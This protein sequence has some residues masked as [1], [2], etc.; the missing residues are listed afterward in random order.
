MKQFIKYV[1]ATIVGIAAIVVV[2]TIFSIIMLVGVSMQDSAPVSVADNSVL[3]IKLNGSIDE[4]TKENPLASIINSDVVESNGLDNMLVAIKHAKDNDNIKGIYIETKAFGGANPATLQE[5]RDALVDFKTSGKFI[6]SYGERYTQGAYYVCSVADSLVVN[7]QGMI[8]WKGLASQVVYYKDLFDKLGV[9]MQVFKVG[10]YKSAVEPFLLSEMSEANREQITTYDTEIWGQLL[11]DVSKSRKLSQDKL[12]E[13]ADSSC[14]FMEPKLYVKHKLADKLAYT[15]EVPQ[16]L[17]NM[18]DVDSPD[19][20]YTVSVKDLANT[21]NSEPKDDSG[22][23]IAVYYAYGDIVDEPSS[24]T[25]NDADEIVGYKVAK[26][27]EKLANDEDVKAVVLRVNSGGGSAYAS[28]QIWNQVQKM[29]A[30]KP[31]IVSMGGL[32]AS[33]GYYISCAADWIVAE[34]TTLTGSIG[35]FGTFPEAGELLNDKLGIHFSTVKTNEYADFGDISRPVNEGEQR[36]LQGYIN[37]GYDLFTRRC[38]NGRGVKQDSIKAIA[39]GRV[40]TGVHAKTIGLVDQLGG[41]DDAIAVAKKKAK[42]DNYSIMSYP[43][44]A[45]I[46]DNLLEEA[47]STSYAND[48]LHELMGEY[49]DMFTIL[50][51]ISD[52]PTVQAS[53]P[54]YLKFN[55]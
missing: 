35:I 52:K 14:M 23:I 34:P 15:D 36:L 29:K 45:N 32:A 30:K 28:E 19:D 33:G 47:T 51:R 10:T 9:S 17:A 39:E 13:L 50:R 8:D 18:M 40:W 46:F 42:V 53:L 43:A 25:L 2:F 6:L 54:Y 12:N 11:K 37:R 55:L 7:P 4:R 44:K 41:L 21:A 20:Y 1:L 24:S 49:Y 31:I 22:N 16:I 27:L 48:Q 26:D 38:A 3:V 5:L